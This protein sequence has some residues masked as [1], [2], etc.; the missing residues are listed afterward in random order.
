MADYVVGIS[1]ASG[2]VLAHLAIET[3]ANLNHRIHLIITPS[4]LLT[5]KEEMGDQYATLD[6][7]VA[8]CSEDAKANVSVHRINDFTSPIASGSY[9]VE[10]MLVIPCSMGTLSSIACGIS[11]NL[12]KR[13]ADVCLKERRRLVIVP[14]EMPFSEIHLNN[15]LTITRAGGVIAPPIPGWYTR[16]ESLRD[17]ENFIVGRALDALGVKSDI[18]P[19]WKA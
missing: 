15:M 1:G 17:V 13:A 6:K 9:P 8:T 5:A 18:Y 19:R 14:R 16:P 10:G 11:D 12:L 7:F 2:I 4:A 3:L